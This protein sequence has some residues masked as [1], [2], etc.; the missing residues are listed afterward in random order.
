M[1]PWI[2]QPI[3]QR[4]KL[5]GRHDQTEKL[6]FYTLLNITMVEPTYF[7]FLFFVKVQN[8]VFNLKTNRA[9]D[10]YKNKFDP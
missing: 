1:E 2:T 4:A 10:S 8:L 3:S 7:Q 6:T 9:M 5:A